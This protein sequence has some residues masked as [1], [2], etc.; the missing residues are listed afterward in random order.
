MIT[1]IEFVS[2][3]SGI[4]TGITTSVGTGGN[5]LAVR[6]DLEFDSTSIIDSL[7][8]GYPIMV[9]NTT[10]GT[11]ITSIDDSDSAVVGIGTTFAD[12]IYY[13][14]AFTRQNLTGIVTANILSTTNHIGIGTT[15]GSYCGSFSWGRLSGFKRGSTAIGIGV[16]GFTVN[17][18]LT[19]YP[20]IQRRDFGLRD[21]GSLRKDLG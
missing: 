15:T 5:P 10:V 19:T 7:E 13:V 16:S 6:F 17:S 12:N 21:N 2:G 20:T 1:G 3:Y 11:G 14:H 8:V 18:G 9:S 4:I